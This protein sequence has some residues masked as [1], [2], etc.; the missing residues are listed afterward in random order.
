MKNNGN[1]QTPNAETRYSLFGENLS[2]STSSNFS[3]INSSK[4]NLELYLDYCN[5][6]SE[7][8]KIIIEKFRK[9]YD[10]GEQIDTILKNDLDDYGKIVVKDYLEWVDQL[11][12]KRM[13][14]WYH[15]KKWL[16]KSFSKK[17]EPQRNQNNYGILQSD[18]FDINRYIQDRWKDQRDYFDKKSISAQKNYRRIQKWLIILSAS[19][20][21]VISLHFNGVLNLLPSQDEIRQKET[22]NNYEICYN[23]LKT[24]RSCL[25]N[26][27]I[28]LDSLEKPLLIADKEITV[29]QE[30]YKLIYLLLQSN[31]NNDTVFLKT[32]VAPKDIQQMGKTWT[33][34][35][36]LDIEKGLC[37]IFSFIIVLLTGFNRLMKHYEEWHRNRENC[38]KLNRELFNFH[39]NV[40]VYQVKDDADLADSV[41]K[42]KNESKFVDRVETIINDYVKDMLSE[43]DKIT[44]Q[45]INEI[46]GEYSKNQVTEQV[47]G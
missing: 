31:L 24:M 38:E 46:L 11:P 21:L 25:N 22:W 10:N 16:Q 18:N 4:K 36:N 19:S 15:L 37:A 41:L 14:W 44:Q 20:T 1:L 32:V 9:K 42:K 35:H 47:H 13:W 17:S 40:G 45:Q 34:F 39:A 30:Q 5:R 8:E 27:T 23:K 33:F 12:P 2:M 6:F 26:D 7:E 3:N 28:T 29:L 43:K